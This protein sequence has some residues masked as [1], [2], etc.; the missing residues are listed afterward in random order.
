VL[1]RTTEGER[2]PARD[3]LMRSELHGPR[4]S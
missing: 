2:D 4:I 3:G 1:G